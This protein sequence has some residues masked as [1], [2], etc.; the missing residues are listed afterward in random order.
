MPFVDHF[1]LSRFCI[2]GMPG[3]VTKICT[4]SNVVRGPFHNNFLGSQFSDFAGNSSVQKLNKAQTKRVNI[5][6]IKYNLQVSTGSS[7]K[8]VLSF[9]CFI[10]A[11]SYL[12][13]CPWRPQYAITAAIHRYNH[14]SDNPVETP[15]PLLCSCIQY[16]GRYSSFLYNPLRQTETDP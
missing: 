8:I 6:V 5:T 12:F 7:V 14:V 3:L 1:V 4:R 15:F 10:Q 2:T 13:P 9:Y 11:N 16:S